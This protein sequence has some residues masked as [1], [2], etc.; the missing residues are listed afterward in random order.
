A[1]PTERQNGGFIAEGYD[2]ALDELRQVSG[3]ARRAIAA[4][5]SRYRG[6]TGISALK[7]RHNGVLGYFI[8]VP[9]RHADALMASDSGFTHR[10][11]MASA[12]RFNSVSL[13]EEASRIAEAG[14]RAL[15]AEEAHFETLVG[16]V[17]GSAREI[18]ATAAALARIDVAA[19]QAERAAEGGWAL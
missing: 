12:V 13:H 17:A 18:A 3:N 5:E 4:L 2:A 8:E 15:A 11:T 1:P 14:A 9:S 7:I 19:G 6:E 10:Q 16:E